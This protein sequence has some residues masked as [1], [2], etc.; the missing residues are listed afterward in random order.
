MHSFYHNAGRAIERYPSHAKKIIERL[1][2]SGNLIS[3]G[4]FRDLELALLRIDRR[5]SERILVRETTSEYLSILKKEIVGLEKDF[6]HFFPQL[7]EYF[8]SKVEIPVQEHWL[9]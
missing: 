5:L 1:I 4:S 6:S 8:K 3:N 9:R 7:I 2:S